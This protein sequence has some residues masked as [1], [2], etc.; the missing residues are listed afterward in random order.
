MNCKLH[1]KVTNGG[2]CDRVVW[3][4]DLKSYVMFPFLTDGL[5]I[6]WINF[7]LRMVVLDS[8]L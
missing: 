2:Q 8:T 1:I 4:L 3:S 6:K 7:V 5:S